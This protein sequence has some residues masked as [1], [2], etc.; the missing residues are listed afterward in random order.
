MPFSAYDSEAIRLL[1]TALAEVMAAADRRLPT[2]EFAAI[3]RAV[4]RKLIE[5]YDDGE[6]DPGALKAAGAAAIGVVVRWIGPK[7]ETQ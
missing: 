3:N 4:T 5:A 7:S 2:G 6:R 1:S